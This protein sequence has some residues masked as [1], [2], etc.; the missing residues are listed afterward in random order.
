MAM[1]PSCLLLEEVSK[2]SYSQATLDS[3]FWL[4]SI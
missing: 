3:D 4:L 2:P 1:F